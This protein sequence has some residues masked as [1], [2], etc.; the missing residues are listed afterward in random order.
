[1]IDERKFYQGPERPSEKL[2]ALLKE[3]AGAH[4]QEWQSPGLILP[5]GRIDKI[6]E[7]D[8]KEVKDIERNLAAVDNPGVQE[9]YRN[10]F[11]ADTPEKI[12]SQWKI[13]RGKELAGQ[14]EKA[15][16]IL[17]ARLMPE[18]LVVRASAYDDYK[19]GVDNII[20][21]KETGDIICAF[22]E[23]RDEPGGQREK[24]KADDFL[25][26]ARRG[27]A[28]I[29]YGLGFEKDEGGARKLVRKEIK[30]IPKFYLSVSKEELTT[31]LAGMN[32]SFDAPPSEA[33]QELFGKLMKS[34]AEQALILKKQTLP[35]AVRANL[36]KFDNFKQKMAGSGI[37]S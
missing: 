19:N 6:Q 16:P 20:L 12:I 8:E 35:Q 27:G 15:A 30:N 2:G 25:K 4:N 11:G 18:F 34:L 32:Y 13:N 14:W 1:M 26:Y 29:K 3:L 22:D 36:E 17:L 24:K 23:V 9:H 37:L 31:L 5:D 28:T 21:D 7:P 10:E 33:E